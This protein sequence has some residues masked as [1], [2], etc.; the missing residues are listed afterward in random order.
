MYDSHTDAMTVTGAVTFSGEHDVV[1]LDDNFSIVVFFSAGL[2]YNEAGYYWVE[3]SDSDPD[4]F[5]R[6][7]WDIYKLETE[8]EVLNYRGTYE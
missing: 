6:G 5:E 2:L 1:E 4:G 3:E 7:G 8:L